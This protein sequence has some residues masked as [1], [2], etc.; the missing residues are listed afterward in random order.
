MDLSEVRLQA[1]ITE[2]QP[3]KIEELAKNISKYSNA[4]TAV[5]VTDFSANDPFHI[6][7][8]Q[9]SETVFLTG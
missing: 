4:Q 1:K 5:N 3:Q 9:L 7:L 8:Q 2:I 6:K